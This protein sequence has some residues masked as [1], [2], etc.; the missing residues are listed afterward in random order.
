MKKNYFLLFLLLFTK[1]LFAQTSTETF[2]TELDGSTNFTD[3]GVTFNIISNSGTFDIQA[4]YPGTGWSGTANDNK[5]IDNS[6][7][8]SSSPSF[9]IKTT[10]NLF[11]ANRFWIYLSTTSLDLNVA[12]SLIITGKLNGIT[13]FTQAKSTGFA[14][15]LGTTNGYTLIDLTNLNGQNYSNIVID[16]LQITTGGAYTYAGLDAFTWV[17][18]SGVILQCLTFSGQPSNSRICAGSNA[19]FS[20]SVINA[21]S[22]QWQVDQGAGFTNVPNV[23]P[24]S[25]AATQTLTIS[26]AIP[27]M[28]GYQY[29]VVASGSC[30]PSATS[31]T[32]ALNVDS[33][34]AITAQPNLST[35]CAGANTTFSVAASNATAYQWQVDQGAGFTNVSNG[36]PYSGA[37][38]ATLTITGATAAMN[39]YVYR[40][41]ATGL[42]SPAATSNPAPLTFYSAPAITAQPNLSTI[43][44]GANTTF[45]V[46]ASN[47]TA[48]QWQ[49]DQGAGFINVSNGATLFWC[50]YS[51]SNYY[52]RNSRN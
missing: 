18:D 22:Y 10:S 38:T 46:S 26:G 4:N 20:A 31:S 51:Y 11:K 27:E 29:R 12:G 48:Y 42:C 44:T 19:S 8:I 45:S 23:A 35:I 21:D 32:A 39:G 43:C 7:S 30:G 16:E 37:T 33:A 24:Y 50:Y 9:S 13:K 40:V 17:K 3:N 41:V 36:A 34:P 2:E 52:W 15:S 1:L 5:Y 14:T 47:A 25:G 6:S 28:N 49:V